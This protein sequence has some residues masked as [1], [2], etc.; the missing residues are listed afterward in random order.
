M[1]RPTKRRQ[2]QRKAVNGLNSAMSTLAP[3]KGNGSCC[4]PKP[5][6]KSP[7]DYRNADG[8]SSQ[9]SVD[10]AAPQTPSPKLQLQE[11]CAIVD[12][13]G[14]DIDT[15]Q[16]GGMD[17]HFARLMEGLSL[18]AAKLSAISSEGLPVASNKPATSTVEGEAARANEAV[19]LPEVDAEYDAPLDSKSDIVNKRKDL[20]GLPNGGT[21]VPTPSGVTITQQTPTSPHP[22]RR[23]KHLALLES[24][25]SESAR[26]VS[27]D[28]R[29]TFGTQD[30]KEQGI[31]AAI[32][33]GLS[34]SVPPIL[35]NI[36]SPPPLPPLHS[37]TNFITSHG[38]THNVN[39]PA[40]PFIPPVRLQNIDPPTSHMPTRTMTS[41]GIH[42]SVV[43]PFLYNPASR[44]TRHGANLSLHQ[45]NLLHI[46]GSDKSQPNVPLSPVTGRFVNRVPDTMPQPPLRYPNNV[47]PHLPRS[48][49]V[50]PPLSTAF[51]IQPGPL[52]GPIAAPGLMMPIA[53]EKFMYPANSSSDRTRL[54][55]LLKPNSNPPSKAPIMPILNADTARRN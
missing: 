30:A 34:S 55:S 4:D 26:M 46:L 8:S 5:S 7:R 28:V 42:D 36:P 17:P 1:N 10:H 32:H 18:S 20:V 16:P 38:P 41:N 29:P 14:K 21:V 54:L 2:Q 53:P 45:G 50:V 47:S 44:P 11:A 15:A 22:A 9:S 43:T 40:P 27:L 37:A 12:D 49:S 25:A 3:L 33:P 6:Y 13:L 35:R 31:R 51:G 52:T 19:P 24:V 48:L 39:T 23:L